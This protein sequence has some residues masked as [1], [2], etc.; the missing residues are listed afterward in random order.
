MSDYLLRIFAK[1]AG[2]RAIACTVPQ[3]VQ[4]AHERHKT[5]AIATV[6]LGRALAGGVLMGATLKVGQEIALKFEGDGPLGKI[7]VEADSNGIVRGYIAQPAIAWSP[8]VHGFEVGKA[9]GRNGLLTVVKDLRLKELYRG[10]V[11]LVSGEIDEDL[12]Y[13]LAQSEQVPALVGLGTVVADSGRVLAAGGLLIQSV[14]PHA[15][16]TLALL[17][18]R[19]AE[20]PPIAEL[21]GAGQTPETFLAELFATIPY[22]TLESRP[23]RFR[24]SCSRER[25]E[26]ALISL[27]ANDLR[28]LLASEGQA[29]I[30]C[31]FCR[32]HYLF[33][34]VDL[35]RLIATLSQ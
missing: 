13:Y 9:V 1:E 16:E 34:A 14:P 26:Q 25:A 6:A 32:E 2:V 20:M 19:L 23:V 24:C 5:E 4:E 27:G 8:A 22:Q 17:S 7:I 21:F 12:A 3:L 31:H 11:P 30:D 28:D 33:A 15:P 29:D 35:E 10:S 18:G